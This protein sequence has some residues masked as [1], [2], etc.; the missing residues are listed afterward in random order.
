MARTP[1]RRDFDVSRFADA[2]LA[3]IKARQITHEAAASECGVYTELF[4]KMRRA[5]TAPSVDAFLN[6][7]AW[8][9]LNPM[10]YRTTERQAPKVAAGAH[11][12]GLLR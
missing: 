1:D 8:A 2:V 3:V 11:F 5:G 6:I 4:S 12:A 10:D 9:G 7:C